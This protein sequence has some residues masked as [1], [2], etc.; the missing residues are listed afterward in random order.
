MP[1]AGK[2]DHG[3][4]DR[5]KHLTLSFEW[6]IAFSSCTESRPNSA[7]EREYQKAPVICSAQ[8]YGGWAVIPCH[9][10]IPLTYWTAEKDM[11]N[12]S[13]YFSTHDGGFGTLRTARSV[14]V[15]ILRCMTRLNRKVPQK[16]ERDLGSTGSLFESITYKIFY[17]RRLVWH[18][19][20]LFD[21]AGMLVGNSGVRIWAP[22]RLNGTGQT[23]IEEYLLCL[24]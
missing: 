1:H 13:G 17:R 6:Q 11:G 10:E 20:Y 9:M 15:R 16:Q 7:Q 21:T 2:V 18:K 19:K 4:D 23:N 24:S 22:K 5:S 3:A 14:A 8:L 12:K